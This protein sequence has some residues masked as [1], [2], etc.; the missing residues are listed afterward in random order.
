M[1]IS[2]LTSGIYFIEI[3]SNT[4]KT[5]QKVVKKGNGN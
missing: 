4:V 2:D 5:V 3:H 1:D